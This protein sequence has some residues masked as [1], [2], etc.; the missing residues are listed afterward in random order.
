MKAQR[1]KTP[2][3]QGV[4]L[5]VL[6]IEQHTRSRLLARRCSDAFL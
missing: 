6:A 1:S 3:D 4:N 5:Y 2:A